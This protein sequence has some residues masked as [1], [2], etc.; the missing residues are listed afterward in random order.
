[1]KIAV[2]GAGPAGLTCAMKLAEAGE[3]VDI[4]EKDD[5]AGGMTK[6]ISL[7]GQSV[8]IGP[9][10]FF[11]M[12]EHVNA[13]WK[14]QVEDRY[15]MVDRLTRIYHDHKFFLYP[16]QAMDALRNLGILEASACV[17]SY[18]KACFAKKGEEKSFE[19][20]V[21]HR[22]GDRLY[23]IFFKTYSERLWGIPCT[24]LDADFAR[25]R[26]KGLDMME[27]IKSMFSTKNRAKHKTLVEQFAYPLHGAGQPY[28]DMAAKFIDRAGHIF[29]RHPVQG[30]KVE[31]G[32][33]VGIVDKDGGVVPYTHVVST[34][35]F[36]DMIKSIHGLPTEVYRAA[37][38]LVYRNTTIVYMKVAKK[39]L[40]KDNWLYIHDTSVTF[41]R[42]TNFRNWS[43]GLMGD[44]EE[45][46]LALEYWSYDDDD[47]WKAD[48]AQMVELATDEVARTGLVDKADVLDG[49]VLRLHRSYPVYSSG[50]QEKLSILQEAA[51][52]TQGVSFI[53][54][55]GSFK[56]N[57]QDHSIL[58]GLL[59]AENILE[60]RK[61]HD[62]WTINTDHDYQ[63]GG[64]AMKKD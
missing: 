50:Y 35:P 64:K 55:N 37:D 18:L 57:N 51:D 41:G 2:I 7:W 49:H 16:V 27:V 63:E 11:S 38:S 12:D 9:H 42:M 28:E 17:L 23:S 3:D 44:Q 22:F 20:W 34:A 53:G 52:G 13:F 26:I 47:L 14:G 10:R 59:A 62:L 1:M 6:T 39:D 40:F 5:V 29:Y 43:P 24:E 46:I 58:M 31:K 4:Y 21:S 56:Y 45:T 48:D 54:R 32:R 25:Q 15:V 8:D 60:G 36:T 30:I 19:E 33:C 61:K